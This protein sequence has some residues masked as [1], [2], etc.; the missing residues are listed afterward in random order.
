MWLNSHRTEQ[1]QDFKALITDPW[2]ASGRRAGQKS[3][4]FERPGRLDGT[5]AVLLEFCCAGV[6]KG[7]SG[8]AS[9]GSRP[10]GRKWGGN[11]RTLHGCGCR[12]GGNASRPRVQ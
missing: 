6:A 3:R 8:S 4:R 10:G 9:I 2:V 1:T 12:I 5:A 11:K 7:E